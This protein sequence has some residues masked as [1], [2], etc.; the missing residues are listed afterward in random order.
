[1]PIFDQLSRAAAERGLKFLVIGGH[2]VIAHGYARTTFDLD[3]FVE[4][5]RRGEWKEVMAGLG[6]K[7]A[8]EHD[9][10]MQFAP[11]SPQSWPVD[12]MLVSADT[13]AGVCGESVKT[14]V[15]SVTVR[16]PSLRHLLALKLHVLKQGAEHR[17][18]KD[19]SDVLQLIEL[20]RM[21]VRTEEFRE[22]CLRYGNVSLYEKFVAACG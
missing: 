17:I 2:A 1:M 12:L 8:A 6:Y 5:S 19:M 4:R 11:P 21:N 9:T 16:I 7:L 3:L 10:F 20:H 18:V 15:E 13:F 22:L 14:R